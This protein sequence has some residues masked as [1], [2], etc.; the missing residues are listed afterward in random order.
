VYNSGELEYSH[1]E[2]GRTYYKEKG[3]KAVEDKEFLDY[4]KKTNPS[5]YRESVKE[6]RRM[7]EDF[8]PNMR[9]KK[10][11]DYDFDDDEIDEVVPSNI[12]KLFKENQM[13]KQR[14]REYKVAHGEGD[15]PRYYRG[16][17][18]SILNELAEMTNVVPASIDISFIEDVEEAAHILMRARNA[19]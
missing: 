10:L 7:R 15:S 11:S 16:R 14:L 8:T 18:D 13:L 4:L 6:Q 3:M 12:K 2:L 5:L 9:G 19:L 1:K 17:L